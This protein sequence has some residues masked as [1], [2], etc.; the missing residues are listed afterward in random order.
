MGIVGGKPERKPGQKRGQGY[1]Q[2]G[3]SQGR[4]RGHGPGS[5]VL[6]PAWRSLGRTGELQPQPQTDVADNSRNRNEAAEKEA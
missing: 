4:D 3:H 5:L 1:R 6:V 2:T